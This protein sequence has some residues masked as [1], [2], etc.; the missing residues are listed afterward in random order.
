MT[1]ERRRPS[2]DGI[3]HVL[4]VV[5]VRDEAQR[6]SACISSIEEAVRHAG[7]ALLARRRPDRSGG[8]S[9][10]IVAVFDACI[11]DSLDIVRRRHPDVAVVIT[12]GRRVGQARACG[13]SVGLGLTSRHVRQ[14][15]IAN[16]DADTVVPPEWLTHQLDLAADG[17]DLVRGLVSPRASEC[18]DRI[19]ERWRDG[20]SPGTG[21]VYVHGANLGIRASAYDS[22]GGFAVDAA[23][24]EDVSLARA[25]ERAG[26]LVVATTAATVT[27]SGRTRG[28]V[29]GGGFADFLNSLASD[30]A[31]TDEAS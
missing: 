27:T 1:V 17:V 10:R 6:V 20:Y 3:R 9:A 19:F 7:L 11:D 8:L 30:H 4:V 31:P 28:R 29:V 14:I 25:V 21:H 18:G 13:V 22:C 2:L 26:L 5:P 15:W 16:T 12:D 23:V 24:H